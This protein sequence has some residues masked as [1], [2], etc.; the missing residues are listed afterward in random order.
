MDVRHLHAE[1]CPQ[2]AT[3]PDMRQPQKLNDENYDG[4]GDV[5]APTGNG[6]RQQGGIGHCDQA[7]SQS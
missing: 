1:K 3:L 2:M 6:N 5:T 4:N 7:K